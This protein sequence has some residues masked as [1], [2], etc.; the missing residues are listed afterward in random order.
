MTAATA[1]R[2]PG[3]G[4]GGSIASITAP[5]RQPG[6]S[7]RDRADR[8]RGICRHE[9][10]S[11][12]GHGVGRGPGRDPD[13]T[14]TF[15]V[16]TGGL[17][18]TAPTSA[19][20]GSG[21]PGRRDLRHPGRRL[22]ANVVVTDLRAT[23]G[24]TWTATAS[25]TDWTLVGGGGTTPEIIPADLATYTPGTITVTGTS[26]AATE[27][28]VITLSGTPA[29]CRHRHR[30]REQH[31]LVGSHDLADRARRGR[32]W[33]LQRHPDSVRGLDPAG[34]GPSR[35]GGGPVSG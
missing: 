14:V 12:S 18:M 21:R 11:D 32:R 3:P 9:R 19:D 25:S 4:I 31:R 20:L 2:R 24:G 7:Y 16:T 33:R 28:H 27:G 10:L 1:R 8:D 35:T 15:T 6:D 23:L 5:S 13:T 34:T 26:N 30:H 29:G 22:G 17:T